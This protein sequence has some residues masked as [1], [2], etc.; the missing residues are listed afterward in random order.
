MTIYDVGII[1]GG[2]S[3][4]AAAIC[5]ARAGARV[6]VLERMERTGKKI[7]ATGN[8]RCNLGNRRLSQ[9]KGAA[10]QVYR[11]RQEG[12]AKQVLDRFSP[13]DVSDFFSSIGIQVVSRD[14]YL[15]PASMQASA[16]RDALEWAALETGRVD[17][18]TGVCVLQAEKNGETGAAAGWISSGQSMFVLSGDDSSRYYCRRLILAAGGMSSPKLGSDGSG[19]R[20]CKAFG[21][22]MITPVPALC[23]LRCEG[24]FFKEIAG[25]RARGRIS[26]IQDGKV[27][28]SDEGELQFTSY[29]VSGIPVFQISRYASYALKKSGSVMVSADLFPDRK[30]GWIRT[31]LMEQAA[32]HPAYT[33]EMILHGVMNSKLADALCK[34]AGCRE[35]AAE[36]WEA[37]RIEDLCSLLKGLRASVT[38]TQG[39][40]N[41]QVTA[42]GADTREVDPYTLSS[43]LVPG[44]YLSGEI[45]DV[46]GICGGYNLCWAFAGGCLAGKSAAQSLQSQGEM[47]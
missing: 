7:L 22:N 17:I 37:G 42:G 33:M 1:G 47:R 14:G 9:S 20:L 26:L 36:K 8:G 15:Y 38:G 29:G 40:D 3:G 11:S 4:M 21:H 19:F 44:L 5:S 18:R 13:E 41:S 16:V 34:M 43:R 46:D 39:F 24:A 45:L 35:C 30:K 12:F 28:A 2:A 32:S 31:Y 23:A 27:A 6:L 10:E 25:V